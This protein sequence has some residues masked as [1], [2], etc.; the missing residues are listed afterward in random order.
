VYTRAR[1]TQHDATSGD[2]RSRVRSRAAHDP[3]TWLYKPN[4]RRHVVAAHTRSRRYG[5]RNRRVGVGLLVACA[6]ALCAL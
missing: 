4:L 6:G 1:Q 5:R 3:E 2:T